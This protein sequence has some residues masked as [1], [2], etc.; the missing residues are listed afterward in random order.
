VCIVKGFIGAC[1]EHVSEELR[2]TI[3]G[4]KQRMLEM[5]QCV[6]DASAA[7]LLFAAASG[8]CLHH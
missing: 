3:E 5:L 8:S 2:Q 6:H 4:N 7:Q 1:S